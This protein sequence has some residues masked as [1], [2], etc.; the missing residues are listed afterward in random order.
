MER[1]GRQSEENRTAHGP[2]R[3]N[4]K[5]K[6]CSRQPTL[7]P[8]KG[9]HIFAAGQDGTGKACSAAGFGLHYF[10]QP[11]RPEGESCQQAIAENRE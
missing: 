1:K 9:R 2:Q 10:L 11:C 7:P 3:K 8:T 5:K 6:A 4:K